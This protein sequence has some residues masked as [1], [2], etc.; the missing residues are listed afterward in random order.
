M[1][2][3]F[4]HCFDGSCAPPFSVTFHNRHLEILSNVLILNTRNNSFKLK[5][6]VKQ[7]AATIMFLW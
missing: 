2:C 3:Q 1:F 4:S 5:G 6:T 7:G